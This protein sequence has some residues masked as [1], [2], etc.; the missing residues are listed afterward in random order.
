[1]LK[2]LGFFVM[3]AGVLS[4]LIGGN[5]LAARHYKRR[6][7][8]VESIAQP[9]AFPLRQFN[10]REWFELGVLAAVSLGLLG[11]GIELLNG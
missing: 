4:W 6:G 10:R 2:L 3:S 1:M 5:V 11:V 8:P 9:G 7:M